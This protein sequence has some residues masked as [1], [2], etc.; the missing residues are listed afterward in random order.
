MFLCVLSL[1]MFETIFCPK[2][3]VTSEHQLDLSNPF[4]RR[5]TGGKNLH[6]L[7]S[8]SEPS[9]NQMLH[10]THLSMLS[11]RVLVGGGGGLPTGN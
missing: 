10:L 11:P 2:H 5:K 4:I 3:G 6:A 1:L 8:F 7:V 9:V